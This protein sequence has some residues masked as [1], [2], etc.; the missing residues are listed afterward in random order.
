MISPYSLDRSAF[1]QQTVQAA[2]DHQSAYKKMNDEE[3]QKVWWMLM[4]A[5]FG[6]VGEQIPVMDK[7]A[8]EQ[9]QRR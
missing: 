8:F 5:A 2:A 1:K 4:A 3:R 6:F 7:T 9:R